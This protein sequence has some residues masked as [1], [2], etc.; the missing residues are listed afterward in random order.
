MRPGFTITDWLKF[1]RIVDRD[2][3]ERLMG[4]LRKAGLPG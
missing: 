2:Y 1:I 4:D 3:A